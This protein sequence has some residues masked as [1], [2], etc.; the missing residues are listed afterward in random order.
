[1]PLLGSRRAHGGAAAGWGGRSG[2]KGLQKGGERELGRA[3]GTRLIAPLRI[4]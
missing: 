2:E 4:A 3:V 1:V